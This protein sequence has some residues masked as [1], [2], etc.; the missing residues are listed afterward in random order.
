[1]NVISPALSFE[2]PGWSAMGKLTCDS[3]YI[4]PEVFSLN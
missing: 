3:A 1:M 2:P 4:A